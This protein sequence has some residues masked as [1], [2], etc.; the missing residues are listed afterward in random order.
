MNQAEAQKSSS[1]GS[2]CPSAEE[3]EKASKQKTSEL[4]AAITK[5]L[6]TLAAPDAACRWRGSSGA[7]APGAAPCGRA[8]RPRR[9]PLRPARPSRPVTGPGVAN[10]SAGARNPTGTWA[11]GRGEPAARP[12]GSTAVT[13]LALVE[14]EPRLTHQPI[15][16]RRRLTWIKPSNSSKEFL[17]QC[18]S[19]ASGSRSAL[20]PCSRLSLLPGIQPI[21]AKADRKPARSNKPRCGQ[22]I[23]SAG[24]PQRP[25]QP[26]VEE[27]PRS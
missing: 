1:A 23:R 10:R 25:V 13:F 11:A 19:T 7:V 5:A 24:R 22:A 2:R 20:R 18:I 12:A 8:G 21:Q 3:I 26:I 4:E 6:T 15:D 27:K 9:R 17:R 16:R 14:Q